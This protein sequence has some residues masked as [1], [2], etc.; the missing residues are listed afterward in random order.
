MKRSV[1]TYHLEMRSP[2]ECRPAQR[3]HPGLRVERV[4]PPSPELNRCLYTTVGKDWHWTDRLVWTDAQWNEYAHRPEVQTW[5]GYVQDTPAG[6]FELEKQP[7]DNVEI[8]YF[9]LLPDFIGQGFGGHLLT[10]AVECAWQMGAR[11]VWVHT[12]S[13]DHPAALSNYQARGFR[14]FQTEET[15]IPA[16]AGGPSGD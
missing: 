16:G 4:N 13:L 14:I 7:Q 11:R 15:G 3:P 8:V 10:R 5:M 6:Y 9:G 12:C 1:V 2:A